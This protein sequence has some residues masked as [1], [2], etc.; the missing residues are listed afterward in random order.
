MIVLDTNALIGH[1]HGPSTSATLLRALADETGHPL[2]IP[3]EVLDEYL[4]RCEREVRP[5]IEAGDAEKLLAQVPYWLTRSDVARGVDGASLP[6]LA[7]VLDDR[8]ESLTKRPSTR[9]VVLP[10]PGG[11]AEEGIAREKTRRPPATEGG[12]E[13]RDVV[14][15]L[16]ALE[17]ANGSWPSNV[18][19]VSSDKRFRGDSPKHLHPELRG[20]APANL[21]FFSSVESLIDKLSCPTEA[22][23]GIPADPAVLAA[24][25]QT[26]THGGH[27]P[28][29]DLRRDLWDW[30]P[31]GARQSD[32]SGAAVS[33]VSEPRVASRRCGDTTFTAV[34]AVYRLQ[35]QYHPVDA[36]PVDVS[37]RLGIIATHG[38]DDF[39]SARVLARGGIRPYG[40]TEQQEESSNGTE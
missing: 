20:E 19:F 32:I 4:A 33:L 2:A 11:A 22:I 13:A 34:D 10:T 26:A 29:H 23:A 6:T 25:E 3:Q 8:R 24:I 18:Y 31:N 27:D 39:R 15:W 37:V 38:D 28:N 21:R 16:T 14:V 17:A 36:E 5:L 35:I 40:P 7:T 12:H 30:V 1:G 9:F